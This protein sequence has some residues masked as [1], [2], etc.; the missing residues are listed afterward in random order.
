MLNFCHNRYFR[1]EREYNF[2][3]LQ[4][5]QCDWTF[6]TCRN[7]KV[8]SVSAFRA[9]KSFSEKREQGSPLMKQWQH[10][11]RWNI[12]RIVQ[13]LSHRQLHHVLKTFV[14]H[15]RDP[16]KVQ[17]AW[18]RMNWW[19]D[20]FARRAKQTIFRVK[21][22]AKGKYETYSCSIARYISQINVK[23]QVSLSISILNDKIIKKYILKSNKSL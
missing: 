15:A 19:K 9:W 20:I 2:R 6:E 14:S 22:H 17:T 7:M 23:C 11:A 13:Y 18:L 10:F 4:S 1:C 12:L 21:K 3:Q 5:C 8:F 16:I